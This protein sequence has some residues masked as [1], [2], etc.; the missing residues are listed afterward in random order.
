MDLLLYWAQMHTEE[1]APPA[2]DDGFRKPEDDYA[3]AYVT[4]EPGNSHKQNTWFLHGALHLFDAGTEIQKFTWINTG[5]R[6]IDQVRDALGKGY[7]PIFVAEGTSQEKLARI[8]HNDYLAKAYRS[9][10]EIGGA[11]FVYGHSL[12][13][14]DEHY[15]KRIE[16]SKKITNLYVGIY[17]DPNSRENKAIMAR[18]RRMDYPKR[19]KPLRVMFFDAASAK[20]WGR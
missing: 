9:F 16:R 12:A 8:R 20:V 4:W 10:I 2:S 3:A 5:V 7:F 18:A 1:G 15:L 14:N 11:L 19:F 17:G 6:L 13:S